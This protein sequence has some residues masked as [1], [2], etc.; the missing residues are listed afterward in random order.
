[1]KQL[2]LVKMSSLGDVVHA[3]P[4]VSDAVAQGWQID[5]VVEE[6]FADIA[7]A[8]PGVRKVIPIAW[9]RWR[10]NLVAAKDEMAGFRAKVGMRQ[11]DRVLDSQGLI[12]SALVTRLAQGP[13]SGYSHTSAREPWSAFFYGQRCQVN[14]AQHAIDRQRQ[15]FAKSLGYELPDELPQIFPISEAHGRTV[16]L[17]HGT[18]WESKHWPES[19]WVGLIDEIK[20]AGYTPL[21]TWGNDDE[22]ARAE[23]FAQAGAELLSKQPLSQLL[24]TIGQQAAVVTVD[25]GLGH[26]SAALG[27]PTM[28][29]YGPT[30]GELTGCRGERADFL[31]GEAPCVPCLSKRCKYRGA[32]LRFQDQ[33]INPAC[34][35]SVTPQRV[36][37]KTQSLM[38][39][40]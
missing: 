25:S 2:L 34:F 3:L 15:L 5:W 9:R 21:V 19:M 40:T 31:Q 6:A 27:V 28:G 26:L 12:K 11:Y 33:V 18:T 14:K 7:R 23:R 38:G 29:I 16:L 22:Q 30:S 13:K 17:L 36:W 1:M 35:A 37:Q 39:N 10:K 4:A 8:H 20:Q 24:T 32:E